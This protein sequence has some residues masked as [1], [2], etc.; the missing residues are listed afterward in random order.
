MSRESNI[1]AATASLIKSIEQ[2]GGDIPVAKL[3]RM[4]ISEFI[5]RVASNGIT[6]VFKS[7]PLDEEQNEEDESED[8]S[9]DVEYDPDKPDY[10]VIYLPHKKGPKGP[11]KYLLL[12]GVNKFKWVANY[13]QAT[14]FADGKD[15]E[16][17]IQQLG[18]PEI[19]KGRVMPIW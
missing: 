15:A 19:D 16:Q 3:L 8:G 17:A 9:D 7:A 2:A 18:S 4:T 14:A 1:I 12:L 6:F 10:W 13:E 11:S 5:E